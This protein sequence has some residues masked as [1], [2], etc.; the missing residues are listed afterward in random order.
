MVVVVVVFAGWNAVW[1]YICHDEGDVFLVST[2]EY[3][4]RSSYTERRMES[5]TRRHKFRTWL[6]WH[7]LAIPVTV[8]DMISNNDIF[9]IVWA[10]G[11][12]RGRTLFSIP[13]ERNLEHSFNITVPWKAVSVRTPR[14][15]HISDRHLV[16]NVILCYCVN[17]AL[18]DSAPN[19]EIFF[20]FCGILYLSWAQQGP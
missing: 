9:V 7:L 4:R 6:L 2:S 5:I 16:A 8:Y 20:H 18:F 1:I 3:H 13:C 12:I 10:Y 14:Y 19:L 11:I 15:H 17:L